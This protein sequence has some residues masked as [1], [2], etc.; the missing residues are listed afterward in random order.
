[1]ECQGALPCAP[2]V[3]TLRDND[4]E[5]VSQAQ[6]DQVIEA[7]YG[8]VVLARQTDDSLRIKQLIVRHLW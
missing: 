7:L 6:S 4:A 5:P 1:M 3:I 8:D 2:T